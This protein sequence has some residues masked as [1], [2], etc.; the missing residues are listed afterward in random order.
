MSVADTGAGMTPEDAQRA[1]AR[2]YKG[3]GSGGSGLGL[4]IAR[5][6]VLAHGGSI[7]IATEPRRGTAIRFTLPPDSTT[8]S[9]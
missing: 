7:D 1:F 4:A 5:G 8:P 3:P 9:Q 2:F 6:L